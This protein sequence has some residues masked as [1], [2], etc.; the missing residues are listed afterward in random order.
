MTAISDLEIFARVARTG[1]MSAAGREMGISPAVVSKRISLLEDRLGARLFQRTTRQLTL[2]ETGEGYFKRVVDVL[3]L[4]EEA[5]DFV[6]RGNAK[7]R[8]LLKVTA[9]TS[10]TRTLLLPH[11][12]DFLTRYPEIEL[13]LQLSEAYIDIIRD[14]FDLAIRVGELPDSSLFAKKI[15]NETRILCAA[16]TY[17]AQHGIPRSPIELE[18]HTCLSPGG[19]DSWRLEGPE[20]QRQV[21]VRGQLRTN[22]ADLVRDAIVHGLGI[23]LRPVWDVHRELAAGAL[24]VILPDWKGPA[25]NGI[26]AVYPSREFMPEKVTVFID[27]LASVFGPEPFWNNPATWTHA[28]AEPPADPV[29][30]S[31]RARVGRVSNRSD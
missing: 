14:G 3:N 28:V 12:P 30:P 17:L 5:E 16:P 1:N 4:I 9:P 31:A 22:S 27:W 25:A 7:P 18:R 29:R 15:A 20:G 26:Y 11:L 10:F 21:R 2:T 23:G 24:R 6:T 13:D 8:G 19:I